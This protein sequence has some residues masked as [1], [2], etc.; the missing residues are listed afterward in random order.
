[1]S[2]NKLTAIGPVVGYLDP[3]T[4]WCSIEH[5]AEITDQ[6]NGVCTVKQRDGITVLLKR[7]VDQLDPL[8]MQHFV[9]GW[10]FETRYI[11]GVVEY[12][13]RHTRKAFP[14]AAITQVVEKSENSVFVRVSGECIIVDRPIREI[15]FTL[16]RSIRL[17]QFSGTVRCIN[18]DMITSWAVYKHGDPCRTVSLDFNL[19]DRDLGGLCDMFD[20]MH[21]DANKILSDLIA[22]DQFVYADTGRRII[23]VHKSR[24]AAIINDAHPNGNA[25]LLDGSTD[26]RWVDCIWGL[27]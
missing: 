1:M 2:R 25:Q 22:T 15:A 19:A 3:H 24:S 16:P 7:S 23:G 4:Y 13:P 6:G 20:V 9:V 8:V 17:Q 14:I 11:D 21:E 10:L 27:R 18:V 12:V 5:I 26:R